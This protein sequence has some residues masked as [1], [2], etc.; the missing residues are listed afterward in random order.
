MSHEVISED[1]MAM[2]DEDT[3]QA[4]GCIYHFPALKKVMLATG[5][6]NFNYMIFHPHVDR[7]IG[8]IT[9]VLYA[10]QGG[11]EKV[12]DLFQRLKFD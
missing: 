4:F 1:W 2:H 9:F 7:P 10:T 5:R 3:E 12:R 8:D 6:N 11:A